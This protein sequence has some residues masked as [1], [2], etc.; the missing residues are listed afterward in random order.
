MILVGRRAVTVA[1]QVLAVVLTALVGSWGCRRVLFACPGKS[2]R[3][4]WKR[5]ASGRMAGPVM[6]YL[7]Y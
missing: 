3:A 1:E 2:K 6:G 4:K 5:K 7:R